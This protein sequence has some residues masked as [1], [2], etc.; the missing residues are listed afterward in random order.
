MTSD[1]TFAKSLSILIGKHMQDKGAELTLQT[2][3]KLLIGLTSSTG[4]N[5]F[6][7]TDNIGTLSISL[8]ENMSPNAPK[9]H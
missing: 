1:D 4:K 6:S 5:T 3:S 2:M 9:K 8:H 7:V